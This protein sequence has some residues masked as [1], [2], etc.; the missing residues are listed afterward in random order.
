MLNL[1]PSEPAEI[2]A[3]LAEI[4]LGCGVCSG[5][6]LDQQFL[7]D[8]AAI[9]V[10]SLGALVD[11]W[12]LVFPRRH[13]LALAEMT[14]LEWTAFDKTLTTVRNRL[15]SKYGPVVLFE[16]GSAGSGRTAACGVNHAHMHV[17][18]LDLDLRQAIARIDDQ[19]G[20][21]SWRPS[22]DRPVTVPAHD[23]IFLLDKSGS[24][25]SHSTHLPGQVVRRAIAFALGDPNWN[26]K[27]NLQEERML[28]V[29]EKLRTL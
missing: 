24:W 11:G 23:Y 17:V 18:A 7:S 26:W 3:D 14:P 22:N 5:L 29:A 21:F 28:R 12:A 20:S 8:P 15:E 16:H 19:V 25:I 27:E 10:A 6:P 9:A 4:A 2:E 13:V 1:I